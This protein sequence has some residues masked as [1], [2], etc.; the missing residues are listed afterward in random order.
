MNNEKNKAVKTWQKPELKS[1]G[2]VEE[3]TKDPAP[4]G[5]ADFIS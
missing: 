4:V 5:S 3:I 1:Y 2:S